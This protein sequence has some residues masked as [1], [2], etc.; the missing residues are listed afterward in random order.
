M[1]K[2]VVIPVVVI[3]MVAAL[4]MYWYYGDRADV[5]IVGLDAPQRLGLQTHSQLNITLMNNESVPVNV[6]IDVK[7]AF[8]GLLS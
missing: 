7:N 8:I 5:R 6:S 4:G 1:R 3:I 2:E